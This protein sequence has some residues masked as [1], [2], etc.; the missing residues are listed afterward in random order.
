M[1]TKL[2]PNRKF[3]LGP[4]GVVL[5]YTPARAKQ[6]GCR[7]IKGAAVTKALKAHRDH[8]PIVAK[9]AVVEDE[10]DTIADR[11]AGEDIDQ[12]ID[13]V[14]IQTRM[15]PTPAE[16]D[17]EEDDLEEDEDEEDDDDAEPEPA[18]VRKRAKAPAKPRRSRSRR[19]RG[20]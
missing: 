2:P 10:S 11:L 20:A 14:D 12:T 1:P 3:I 18:P 16:D 5:H 9:P 19:T 15:D 7:V 17:D 8:K 13:T 6:A 4:N